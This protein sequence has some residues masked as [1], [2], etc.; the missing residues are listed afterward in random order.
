[1][2]SPF[3]FL[4]VFFDFLIDM[5]AFS[6]YNKGVESVTFSKSII[7]YY[8]MENSCI[9]IGRGGKVTTNA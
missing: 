1:M 8:T 2:I 3:I 7:I 5:Y 9:A 4:Y 6:Y